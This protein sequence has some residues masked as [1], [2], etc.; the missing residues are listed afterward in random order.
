[1]MASARCVA[2]VERVSRRLRPWAE[3]GEGAFVKPDDAAVATERLSRN[4][5]RFAANYL[6]IVSVVAALALAGRPLVLLA[7]ACIAVV[8]ATAAEELTDTVGAGALVTGALIVVLGDALA[9]L[10]AGVAVGWA[11][12]AA[13]AVFRS[14]DP[15]PVGR[16]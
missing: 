10:L 2:V 5:T 15:T 12:V 4:V 8:A 9:Q 7:L 11:V 6:L 13:H 16:V 3:L 14:S 1:M